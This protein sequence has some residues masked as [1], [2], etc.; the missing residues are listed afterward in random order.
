MEGYIRAAGRISREAV[1]DPGARAIT[2]S[3]SIAARH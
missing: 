3:Y 1:G 2:Q